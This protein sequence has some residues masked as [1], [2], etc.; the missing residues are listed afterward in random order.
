[1]NYNVLTYIFY[2]IIILFVVT[3]VGAMLYRNGIHFL[4]NTF[5]GDKTIATAV[6]KFF[7]AGYYLLNI[8]YSIIVLRIWEKVNSLQAMLEALS[9]KAGGIILTLGIMHL[10]N[11]LVLI[12]IGKKNHTNHSIH[13]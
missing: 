9:F 12:Y 13:N 1:M 7:L 5:H 4:I 6:N 10:I 11:L 8:G 2:L 3:Y